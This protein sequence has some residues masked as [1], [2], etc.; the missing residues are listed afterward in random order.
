[1]QCKS[2]K[3]QCPDAGPYS[4]ALHGSCVSCDHLLCPSCLKE[5]SIAD[6]EGDVF[7]V[8]NVGKRG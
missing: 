1:M 2:I 6:Q 8:K 7:S 4:V 5:E 3:G